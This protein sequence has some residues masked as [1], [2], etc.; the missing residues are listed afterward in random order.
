MDPRPAAAPDVTFPP[1]PA[2]SAA[3][4]WLH[5]VNDAAPDDT[6]E[7]YR[8]RYAKALLEEGSAERRRDIVHY[9]RG[10]EG[11][12][13]LRSIEHA[14]ETRI[15]AILETERTEGRQR[16]TIEVEPSPPH[17]IVKCAAEWTRPLDEAER[18]SLVDGIAST[19]Q[20]H[21][22]FRDQAQEMTLALRGHAARGDYDA[23]RESVEFATRVTADLRAVSHDRHLSLEFGHVSALPEPTKE[24]RRAWLRNANF[25]FGPIERLAGNVA[26]LVL[27]G[28]LDAE[29]DEARAGI[30]ALMS[31]VADADALII[32]LRAN[33][34]GS[35][36]TLTLVASYLFD[37]TPVHV[38]DVVRRDDGTT[39]Q[40]WTLR[41]VEGERFGAQKPVYVITSKKTFSCAEA[42]AYHLQSLRRVTVVGETTGGGAHPC[43]NY[44]LTD[45]F[46]LQVPW[47]RAIDPITKTNWERAGVVPDVAVPAD[48]ALQEAY[49]RA[50]AVKAA[51]GKPPNDR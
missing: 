3:A 14:S 48:S 9:L 16:L 19:L 43:A 34:G 22:V 5:A 24:Q 42:F 27:D 12:R 30:G 40:Y 35:P 36:T 11:R 23:V 26:H 47:G 46:H 17:A 1:S 6:L 51:S 49:R 39:T 41:D 4:E 7:F 44:R 21:Y 18:R 8:T 28:F 20:R 32:D 10:A 15:V 29:D 31:K 37:A 45:W 33:D 25:G 2:G 50:L 38:S 13:R